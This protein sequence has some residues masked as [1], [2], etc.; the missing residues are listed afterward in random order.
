MTAVPG[1]IG[2][3]WK[4]IHFGWSGRS[5]PTGPHVFPARNRRVPFK[6]TPILLPTDVLLR[7]N[8]RILDPTTAAQPSFAGGGRQPKLRRDAAARIAYEPTAYVANQ[9]LISA[10]GRGTDLIR[11]L[12]GSSIASCGTRGTSPTA[13]SGSD[14]L[15]G[16]ISDL[17]DRLVPSRSPAV[18]RL[19]I[20]YAPGPAEPTPAEDEPTEPP[21]RGPGPRLPDAW[22]VVQ[23]L[24]DAGVASVR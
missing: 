12:T 2:E 16:P 1:H 14:C 13:G 6:E 3:T 11:D 10:M 22:E 19:I 8:A 7:H 18:I 15:I 4:R 23:R 17:T 24:R 9:V 21:D 20:D 5:S